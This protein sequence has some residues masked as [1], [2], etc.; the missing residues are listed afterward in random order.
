ML[1]GEN[2]GRHSHT[3]RINKHVLFGCQSIRLFNTEQNVSP[4]PNIQ[5]T[6]EFRLTLRLRLILKMRLKLRLSLRLRI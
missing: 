3:F 2:K 6:L 5:E 4:D 1:R